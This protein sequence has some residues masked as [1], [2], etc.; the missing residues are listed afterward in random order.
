MQSCDCIIDNISEFKRKALQWATS[1]EVA[2]FLD[3]NGYTDR[4]T[5]HSAIIAAGVHKEYTPE[6]G[7]AFEGLDAFLKDNSTFTPGFMCYDLKNELE[8]LKS[9]NQDKLDFP[10]MYFFVP[11]H[12][13]FINGNTVTIYSDAPFLREEINAIDLFSSELKFNGKMQAGLSREVY[14]DKVNR[15][16]EHIQRGDIYEMNF[17]QQFFSEDADIDPLAAYIALN[18]I[19]PAPF[20]SFFKLSDKYIISSSPE[21]FIKKTGPKVIS[22]PIKG[23]APRGTDRSEDEEFKQSLRANDKELAENIMIVDLVRNDLTRTAVP[24]S[25][26][27]E[28]LCEIYSFQQVHQ[29]ISTVTSSVAENT[30]PVSIIKNAFPMGSMTGAPKVR[31]MELIEEFEETKRGAYSGSVGYFTADK[32]FDFNVV[33]RSL[34]YNQTRQYLSFQVGSAITFASDAE[35]EYKECMLKAK[36]MLTILS[37]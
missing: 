17:C 31:A 3:S 35:L 23:T 2:C 27:V 19:S 21:R 13:L 18:K 29:M 6:P 32:D 15:I 1:F 26:R 8:N 34:V 28:E 12:L 4:Y 20:S 22:Q 37:E 5:S 10:E 11:E 14:I 7:A 9:S 36:A 30:S 25:V 33:I 24:G 16:K